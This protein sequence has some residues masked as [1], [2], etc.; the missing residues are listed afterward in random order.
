VL[1]TL[2]RRRR[3]RKKKQK[4]K[5]EREQRQTYPKRSPPSFPKGNP[6]ILKTNKHIN[7][8]NVKKIRRKERKKEFRAPTQ[9]PTKSLSLSHEGTQ[10]TKRNQQKTLFPCMELLR[11][12]LPFF[13]FLLPARIQAL[14]PRRVYRIASHHIISHLPPPP[15]VV[16]ETAYLHL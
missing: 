5:V 6:I 14:V 11:L 9:G 7:E 16:A 13:F 12:F 1:T 4:D 10:N 8:K 3:T 2:A 15:H